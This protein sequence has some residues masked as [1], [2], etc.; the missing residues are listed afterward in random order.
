MVAAIGAGGAFAAAAAK[1]LVRNTDMGARQI[2]EEAITI[3][4]DICVYTN[5][6]I[7]VDEL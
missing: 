6:C 1:A 3:A 5:S 2:V 7:T 4:A